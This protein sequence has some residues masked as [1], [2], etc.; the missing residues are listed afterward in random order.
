MNKRGKR[1]Y[2]KITELKDNW[3]YQCVGNRDW[4]W[5]RSS[6]SPEDEIISALDGDIEKD[7]SPSGID[8][9]EV[10]TETERTVVFLYLWDGMSFQ[11]IGKVLGYTKQR[12]HQIYHG[13]IKCLKSG[14]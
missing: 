9:L 13:A 12:I 3:R 4:V 8:L 2:E 1:S 6:H 7:P 5:D 10:L 14:A 11:K